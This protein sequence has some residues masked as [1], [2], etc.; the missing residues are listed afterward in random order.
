MTINC[1]CVN[2]SEQVYKCW[3]MGQNVNNQWIQV[4]S[5]QKFLVL[6]LQLFHEFEIIS[7]VTKNNI[8]KIKILVISCIVQV[9][10]E[11]FKNTKF[12]QEKKF[13]SIFNKRTTQEQEVLTSQTYHFQ[14]TQ[15]LLAHQVVRL[16][17]ES[18]IEYNN[19]LL[20][21]LLPEEGLAL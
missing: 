11:T 14:G 15:A 18:S 8:R 13:P 3:K 16:E 5:T 4:K 2:K 17:L 7:K 12:T 9:R 20:P 1:M 6:F 21:K 10:L 19:L